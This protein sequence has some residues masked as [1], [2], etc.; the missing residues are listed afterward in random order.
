MSV[1][2]LRSG[3]KGEEVAAEDE[4]LSLRDILVMILRHR[5]PVA[6]FVLLVTLAAGIFFFIQPRPFKAEGYLQVIP[7]VSLEGRVDKDRFE[8]MIVSHLQRVSSAFIAKNVAVALSAKGY[9]ITPLKLEQ[10]IKIT[11]PP[12]TDLVRLVAQD[13]S[14]EYAMLIVRQWIKQYLVSFQKNNIRT[15]LPQVRLLL[16]KARADLLEQQAVVDKMKIQVGLTAPLVTI[17]RAVDDRQLW[18]DLTQ[19]TVPDP[20]VMKKLAEM[21]IK[22][23]EQSSEYIGL[24]MALHKAEQLQSSAQAR[25][26]FYQEV[27]RILEERISSNGSN[28]VAMPASTNT[29]L[30][31]AETYVK[32]VLQNV[33][34]VQ[35]GEPGL[36]VSRRGALKNTALVFM[37]A[38]VLACLGAFLCEWGKGL[39][40]SR[41]G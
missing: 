11:R 7:P 4:F 28:P 10:M 40:S 27:E 41:P 3:G 36:I 17:S 25:R 39:L 30:S 8:T 1:D 34:I 33:E 37:A 18:D 31:D 6:I 16:K 32:M 24:K 19:K 13:K 5:W 29:I 9:P 2:M 20:E 22:G 12:K 21:H 14:A 35:F 38:L 23:Q 26:D 15:T